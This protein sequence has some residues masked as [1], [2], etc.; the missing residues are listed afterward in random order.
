MTLDNTEHQN[1]G[2]IKFSCDIWLRHTCQERLAPKSLEID[3]N[4][5]RMKFSAL[6]VVYISLNFSLL[7]SRNFSYGM[8]KLGTL[9]KCSLSAAQTVTD[10]RDRLRPLATIDAS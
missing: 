1:R 8:S 4:K 3:Q 9:S 2:F 7:C 6:N 10:V 5:L